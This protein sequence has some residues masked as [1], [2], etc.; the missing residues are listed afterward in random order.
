MRTLPPVLVPVLV[1]VAVVGYLVGIHRPSAPAARSTTAAAVGSTRIAS[2]SN[3]LLSYPSSWQPTGESLA[4]PGL[5]IAHPLL[6]APSGEATKAGLLSGQFSGEG[7][8][9]LPASFVA[10]FHG[11][12][13]AEIVSL[14]N[15]QAYRYDKLQGYDRTLDLYVIPT[16][17][18]SPTALVCYAANGSS[19]YLHQ[20]EGIVSNV[21]LVGQSSYDLIPSS[22]YSSQLAATVA[23]LDRERVKLRGEIHQRATLASVAPLASALATRFENAS[24]S[25][26]SL[27]APQAASAAQTSLSSA[28]M[29]AHA[30]YSTLATAS[31]AESP[32][33]YDAAQR[34]VE[35]AEAAVDSALE[36][37]ALLGYAS[38]P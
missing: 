25:L 35:Q 5:T 16:V 3:I 33:Q 1:V 37:Y 18:G 30:A 32:E 9:P 8:S 17:G 23:K 14:A 31:A 26:S 20:C 6:L 15:A 22:S 7:P 13:R 19:S 21:S 24:S 12:P 36:S 2:G 4:I 27:E 38:N 34:Q 10:L 11:I 28:L 29:S